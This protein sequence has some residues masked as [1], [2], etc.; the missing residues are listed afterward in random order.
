VGDPTDHQETNTFSSTV[1]LIRCQYA[2]NSVVVPPGFAIHQS[3]PQRLLQERNVSAVVS[4]NS[5]MARTEVLWILWTVH[6][7][8]FLREVCP[9]G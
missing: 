3:R 5:D 7:S 1:S 8:R 2:E 9:G 6:I 4:K